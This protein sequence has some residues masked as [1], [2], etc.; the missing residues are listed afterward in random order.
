MKAL[1]FLAFALIASPVL[2]QTRQP[3]QI[4][5]LPTTSPQEFDL[6]DKT[7]KWLPLNA[8]SGGS[9]IDVRSAGCVADGVTDQ[10]ACIQSV[11]TNGPDCAL[12]PAT[13][14][15]FYVDNSG[16]PLVA[17]CLRGTVFSPGNTTLDLSGTSRILCNNQVAGPCLVVDRQAQSGAQIEN[18]SL[19]GSSGG[20]VMATPV[21]GAIG[22][23]WKTGANL[24][25]SNFQIANFDSC[26]YYG[27]IVGSGKGPINAHMNRSFFGRCHKHTVV[28]D[29]VPGLY[30]IGGAWGTDGASE[31]TTTDDYLYATKT[32]N[33]AGGDGP[34]TIILDSVIMNSN[35]VGCPIRW[36]GF[37]ASPTGVFLANKIVNSHIEILDTGYTGSA[38]QG[39]FCVDATVPYFPQYQ[40][41]NSV[42]LTDGG[43][44]NH[45]LFNVAPAIP[46]TAPTSFVNNWLGAGPV[47]LTISHVSAGAGPM[48]T[49]NLFFPPSQT[50]TAGDTTA[51]LWLANNVMGAHTI[52]GQWANLFM[53]NNLGGVVDNATGVVHEGGGPQ[54]SWTPALSASGGGTFAYSA[55]AGAWFR[56]PLGGLSAWFNIGLTSVT[57]ASGNVSITGIPKNCIQPTGA[58]LATASGFTGLTG[59]PAFAWVNGSSTIN[60]QQGTATG[61]ANLTA[62]N[63]T[64][65]TSIIGSVTCGQAQ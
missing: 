9:G 55:Q 24:V 20:N 15:G 19:I 16:G 44:T 28:D 37:I 58:I 6:L 8:A 39:M 2:A 30:F 52:A 11:L 1:A 43:S 53:D 38:T 40:V 61:L 51:T 59:T 29:G 49:N 48:F 42:I 3:A 25:M 12:I 57:G 17:R 10:R 64:N 35:Y 65:T 60:M 56:T 14:L 36:G 62:A 63:L 47:N 18:V 4:T 31:Y 45:P 7:G 21:S 41:A 27:P 5:T 22:F 13:P 26:A 54:R 32:A 50:F 33:Y 46:W 23:Q 34:N